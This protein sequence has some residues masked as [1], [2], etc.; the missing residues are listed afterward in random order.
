MTPREELEAIIAKLA[1]R[2]EEVDEELEALLTAREL[3]I[4]RQAQA[5]H[6]E[7][8]EPEFTTIAQVQAWERGERPRVYAPGELDALGEDAHEAKLDHLREDGAV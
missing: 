1:T 4:A 5:D 3:D 8:V 2:L 6:E 7:E